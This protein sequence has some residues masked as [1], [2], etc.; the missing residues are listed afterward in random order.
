MSNYFS[1]PRNVELSI[2]DYIET[3][4]NSAWSG[5]S[6]VKSFSQAYKTTRPVVCILLH[7]TDSIRREVGSTSLNNTYNILIHIFSTSDGQ[8]IDLSNF[9]LNQLKEGCVYYEFSQTSG[10]PGTLSK[11]ANGRIHVTQFLSNQKIDFGD[12]S[13]EWD[14]FRSFISILVKKSE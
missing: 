2:I 1:E 10:S 12:D 8:R 11:T 7:D 6:T 14:K 13:D 4:V 9:I 5:I 3:Q